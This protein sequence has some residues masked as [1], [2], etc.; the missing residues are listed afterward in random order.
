MILLAILF[1]LLIWAIL[2]CISG[3]IIFVVVNLVA[4]AF[5]LTGITFLQAFALGIAISFVTSI[6]RAIFGK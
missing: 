4:L 5:S 1:A 3:V 2:A 6:L